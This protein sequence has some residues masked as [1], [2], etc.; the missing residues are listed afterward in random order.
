M[1]KT[2]GLEN[3]NLFL[4]GW[5][6]NSKFE[7]SSSRD[8]MLHKSTFENF[9]YLNIDN[10]VLFSASQID[11]KDNYWLLLIYVDFLQS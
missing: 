6:S 3:E 7:R 4:L 5:F 9:Y 1:L 8:Y 2:K 11:S 10:W